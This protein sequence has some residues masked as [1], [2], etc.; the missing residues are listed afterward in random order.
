MGKRMSAHH[1]NSQAALIA[2]N[3]WRMAKRRAG[4]LGQTAGFNPKVLNPIAENALAGS[5]SQDSDAAPDL[6]PHPRGP[7]GPAHRTKPDILTG[8]LSALAEELEEEDLL[9]E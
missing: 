1:A 7:E 5:L 2:R 8:F 3:M 9:G 4:L 6:R